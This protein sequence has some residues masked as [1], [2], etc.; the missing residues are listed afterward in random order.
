[1]NFEISY[2]LGATVYWNMEVGQFSLAQDKGETVI[3]ETEYILSSNASVALL[4]LPYI[5]NIMHFLT[6]F[7]NCRNNSM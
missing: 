5:Q 7:Q 3:A 1:M 6:Y 4:F 2:I